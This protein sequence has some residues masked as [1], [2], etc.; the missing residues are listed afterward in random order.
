MGV[1]LD[2]NVLV[3]LLI[4]D[5]LTSKATA[6]VAKLT[7]PLV[8]SDLA[9][10]EFA[11]TIA[12]KVREGDMSRKDARI[13]LVNFDS[14]IAASER[15]QLEGGDVAS[16]DAIVRRLDINLHGADALHVAVAKRVGAALL[17]L[18][19]KMRAN[20]QKAGLSVV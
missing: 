17:T 14:W 20:A 2:A 13:A 11:S 5:A 7:D 9:A 12:R 3:A 15:V 10:L 4:P 16:A 18:D 1:Y 19:S 8:V 6:A